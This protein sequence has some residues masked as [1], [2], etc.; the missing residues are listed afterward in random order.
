MTTVRNDA[1][2]DELLPRNCDIKRRDLLPPGSREDKK[3]KEMKIL[4]KIIYID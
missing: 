2:D 1:F 4:E 3:K